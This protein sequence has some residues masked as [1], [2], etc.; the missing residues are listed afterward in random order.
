MRD[1]FIMWLAQGFGAGRIPFAP[2]TFGSI[3]GMVWFAL[4]LQLQSPVLFC[5]GIILSIFLSVW[6]CGEGEKIL[7]EK[8]PGSIVMDEI[9]AIPICFASW[10][11]FLKFQ[12]GF[13][14]RPEYFFSEKIRMTAGVFLLF[15][16]FDVA[17]PWPIKQS[18]TFP[19]GWGVTIDDVLAA[20][21]VNGV[22]GIAIFLGPKWF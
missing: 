2:G 4:F 16:F 7:K 20:I 10:L 5:G 21:Y 6:V 8:D 18:Q 3:V 1:K 15:R 9:I 11:L 14:P 19:G 17:K 13:W 12:K 22:V